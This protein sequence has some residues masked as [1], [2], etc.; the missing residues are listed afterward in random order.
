MI[1]TKAGVTAQEWGDQY[2]LLGPCFD[3]HVRT[4]VEVLEP[5]Y[6]AF[7]E[8]IDQMRSHGLKVFIL[9]VLLRSMQYFTTLYC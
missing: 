8:T 6:G 4:E 1:R 2:T 3:Q 9:I 7:K 5:E